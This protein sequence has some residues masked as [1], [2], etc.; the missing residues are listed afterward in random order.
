[1][2]DTHADSGLQEKLSAFALFE[3]LDAR[4]RERLVQKARWRRI[5][6]GRPVLDRDSGARD[7]FFVAQGLV[8]VSNH[9]YSGRQISFEDIGPGGFFG[10]LAAIDGQ[11]RSANV[12][13]IEESLIAGLD[14]QQFTSLVTAHPA[15]ALAVMKRLAFMVRQASKR[16][17]DVS[18]QPAEDRVCKEL[19]RLAAAS[20]GAGDAAAVV[21]S[22]FPSHSA[23]ASRVSTTRE[24]VARIL[25]GLT[26]SG[27]IKRKQDVVVID[28]L[29][30]LAAM[31]E[32]KDS[33]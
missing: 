20:S 12:E 17:V 26:R 23:I 16:I 3:A 21:I 33:E 32:D 5:P 6:A 27:L 29:L 2:V 7:V 19:L 13:T 10:E 30:R 4:E 15:V 9:S 14:A 25:G 8:R 31:V 11:P 1:M 28:D 22:P 18:T 24:T